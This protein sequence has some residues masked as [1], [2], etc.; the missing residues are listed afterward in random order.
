MV[1]V[2]SKNCVQTGTHSRALGVVAWT[3]VEGGG[4]AYPSRYQVLV[5]RAEREEERV[6]SLLQPQWVPSYA[7]PSAQKRRGR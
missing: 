7:G 4:G 2:L 5:L 3:E 1:L 6:P